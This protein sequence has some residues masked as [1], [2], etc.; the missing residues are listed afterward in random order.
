MKNPQ[1]VAFVK[2]ANIANRPQQ[3]NNSVAQIPRTRNFGESVKR[4]IGAEP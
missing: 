4:T 1:P 2:Q 3:V